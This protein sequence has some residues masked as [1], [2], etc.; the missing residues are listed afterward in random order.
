[1]LGYF[2][3]LVFFRLAHSSTEIVLPIPFVTFQMTLQMAECYWCT[4]NPG[5]LRL[6]YMFWYFIKLLS[7]DLAVVSRVTQNPLRH[8]CIL[9][10][11]FQLWLTVA[12]SPPPLF[13]SFSKASLSTWSF[14]RDIWHDDTGV[15]QVTSLETQRHEEKSKTLLISL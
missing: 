15:W 4:E 6:G 9:L 11:L 3:Q 13:V 8:S 10:C 5:S 14:P 2:R 7:L 1:M 12:F